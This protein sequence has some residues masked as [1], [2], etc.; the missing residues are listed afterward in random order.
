[1][2]STLKKTHTS[3]EADEAVGQ[4]E[5]LVQ[6]YEKDAFLLDALSEFI[7]TGFD[8]E[9]ACLVIATK[10]HREALEE[11][12]QANGLD[13]AA[14]HMRGEYLSLDAAETLSQFMVDGWPEQERFSEVVRS[15]IVRAAKD[16]RHVRIFGEMVAL[17]WTE[18][19]Q[20]AAIR[21]EELWNELQ[22][23]TSPFSLLCAYSMD[24]FAGEMYGEPFTEICQQHSGVIPDENYTRLRSPDERLRT[25][26][27]LQ[28]KA[29]S[30][31]TEIAERK[32]AEE[33]FRAIVRFS[34]D[35][36]FLVDP[37]QDRILEVNPKACSLLGYS[38]EELLKLSMSTILP[39]ESPKLHTFARMVRETGEGWTDEL[40]CLTKR[41]VRIPAEISASRVDL[42]GRTCLLALMRDIRERKELERQKE[43]LVSMVTHELKTPLTAL[44]GNIQ[45]AHRRL[46]RLESLLTPEQADQSRLLQEALSLLSRGQELLHVQNR[47]INDLLDASRM[48]QNTLELQLTPCDLVS[49]VHDIVHDY[50]AA[51]PRRLITLQLP[52][53]EELLVQADRDRIGQV[54]GNYLTNALK[55]SSADQPVHV[56]LTS[57]PTSA[58]LWVQDHG[59]GLSEEAQHHI[60][61]QFY[62]VPG[63]HAQSK[64]GA[65]L[66]LGLYICQ[67]LISSHHGQVGV[68]SIPGQ[69]SR[70]WFRLPLLP[71][72]A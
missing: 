35:A 64:G 50:Q 42:H 21:L 17:L 3:P 7:E 14:A 70:F 30:L 57:E 60:W 65:S 12:L 55:Y 26:T 6:F 2:A 44:Q 24:N 20:A 46:R 61:E 41:G 38:Y 48:Q 22:H 13:L 27:L 29:N 40:T 54:I 72:D 47:L 31:Q 63:I 10:A 49:L 43:A 9:D 67:K 1:M 23:T 58:H 51:H 19:N 36:I 8:A 45:L 68:E 5:H 66:G 56:G 15:I 39:D 33:R 37:A 4:C 34:N 69:G 52:D 71:K 11:R 62:Q 18:D 28:Q 16:R 53:Q 32:A 59:P 25:I